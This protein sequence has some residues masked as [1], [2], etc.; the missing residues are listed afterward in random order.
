M[1]ARAISGIGFYTEKQMYRQTERFLYRKWTDRL[2]LS[3]LMGIPQSTIC[4]II[5]QYLFI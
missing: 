1:L 5:K 3:P 2:T 4:E